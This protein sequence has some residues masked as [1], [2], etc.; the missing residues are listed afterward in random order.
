[1]KIGLISDTHGRNLPR[2]VFE[3]FGG[4]E[5]ILHAGDIMTLDTLDILRSIAPVEA[6]VG[7]IDSPANAHL[8]G[9]KKLLT[10]GGVTIGL[11]HGDQGVGSNTPERAR[12]AFEKDLVEVVVFGHSHQP[13]IRKV[14]GVLLV[15]PGSATDPRQQEFPSIGLLHTG[16]PIEAEIR[17]LP[18]RLPRTKFD[19]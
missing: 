11:V 6:V 13:L 12:R 3:I 15:N 10:A 7:N 4:V 16:P 17:L 9:R 14:G 1:M 8:V 18:R 19:V 2:E 5:L